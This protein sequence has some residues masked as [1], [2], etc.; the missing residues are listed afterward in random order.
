MVDS[1]FTKVRDTMPP[2]FGTILDDQVKLDI[3][4]YILQTN[5]FPAERRS[6]G[7]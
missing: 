2:N 7:R 1:L 4:T 6:P 3:V 5:G